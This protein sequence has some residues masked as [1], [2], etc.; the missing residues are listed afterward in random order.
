MRTRWT[1]RTTKKCLV[2]C[3]IISLSAVSCQTTGGSATMG[4]LLAG[5]AGAIIGHQSGHAVEGAAIGALIGGL[6]GA[7]IHKAR[8]RQLATRAEVEQ[9]FRA[10]GVD[11]STEP[12]VEIEALQTLPQSV[13]PG[14]TVSVQGRYTAIGAD[15]PKPEGTFRLLKDDAQVAT[16]PLEI[17]NTGRSEFEKNIA[18]PADFPDGTYEC[19]VSIKQGDSQQVKRAPFMVASGS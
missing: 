18:V 13:R 19:E 14:E 2:V 15:A 5:A 6:S 8:E 4:S 11:V 12:Q 9:E 17:T 10:K 1:S 7:V 16:S 3:V